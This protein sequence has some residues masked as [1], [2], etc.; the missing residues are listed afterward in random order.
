MC[1][2]FYQVG[3]KGEEGFVLPRTGKQWREIGHGLPSTELVQCVAG[4]G[5]RALKVWNLPK[6]IT[7]HPDI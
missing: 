1:V 6:G 3:I 4:T 5:Q 2:C 7:H